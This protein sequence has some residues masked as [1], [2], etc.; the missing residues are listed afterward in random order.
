M[1][2]LRSNRFALLSL[3]ALI[4]VAAGSSWTGAIKKG[5]SPLRSEGFQRIRF[6]PVTYLKA[7]LFA[8]PEQLRMGRWNDTVS[9]SDYGRSDVIHTPAGAFRLTRGSRDVENFLLHQNSGNGQRPLF[10]RGAQGGGLPEVG[11]YVVRA[12]QRSEMHALRA[13]VREHG[14]RIVGG[15]ANTAL[16]VHG[17]PSEVL[18]FS[19]TPRGET[20]M[21]VPADLKI[22]HDLGAAPSRQRLRAQSNTIYASAKIIGASDA[23][24][25]EMANN[26]R[27]QANRVYGHYRLPNGD[28]RLL[29]DT[30]NKG[31]IIQLARDHRVIAIHSRREYAQQMNAM[32]P[33]VIM[34]GHYNFGAVPMWDAGIDGGGDP[35]SGVEPQFVAVS[36]DGL[37]LDTFQF[38]HDLTDPDIDPANDTNPLAA[39]DVG[40]GHRKIESYRRV[41]DDIL[42]DAGISGI[43]VGDFTTCDAPTS[44]GKT[45][46]NTVAVMVA[47]NPSRG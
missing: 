15:Y 35:S 18:T 10:V 43:V 8:P 25:A 27:G 45:H 40:A 47:G 17:R 26:L 14:L 36:D 7:P 19:R 38:S 2:S 11:L 4:V 20:L 34:T 12:S 29:F 9:L 23:E 31:A 42:E 39:P 44:G 3:A 30:D 1:N 16:L 37:S 46:G 41:G 22:A 13:E 21:L 5:E 32:I 33:S 28:A 6:S 24:I